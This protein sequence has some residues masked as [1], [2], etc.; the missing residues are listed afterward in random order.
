[1]KVLYIVG[2]STGGLPHYTA[3]LAN[4]VAEHA[5]VT[6]MKPK[7]TT[8]DELF[9][10][11]V[12]LLTAFDHLGVSMPELYSFD[13]NPLDFV[14][15]FLSYDAIREIEDVDAD[16]VHDTTDL[17]PQVK[18]FAKRHGIDA[19]FPL[20]V[21][22]HEVSK[23]RLS[24]S[25]PPV[26]VEE[27]LD[28]AI[29]DLDLDRVVVHTEKQRR[30]MTN[31]GVPADR[32]SIIPHGAYS[33]F[34]SD[35]DVDV[36]PE[37]NCLLFFGHIVT[38]K[39]LDTLVE[40]IP[41]VKR[42]IP[43][44]KLIIA[45]EGKIPRRSRAIME[46]HEGNFEVHNYFVPNEEVKDIFGRAEVVA[47]PYRNQGGTKGHSGA[48]A[49]AFSFGKPVVASTAGEFTSLVG[50]TGSGLVV[51][52]EDPE[53]LASAIIRLLTDEDAKREMSACSSRMADRLSWDNVAEQYVDVY[54]R[55][56]DGAGR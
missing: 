56:L 46:A 26:L 2:Q 31:R 19:R 25:R 37:R 33:V 6:V 10:D 48:L 16:V 12:E 43:D 17:F 42:E 21:T 8:A 4:A 45:G 40:A 7:E 22:R 9:D 35:T 1:M 27:L 36:D 50:D 55:V 39:G 44:V 51:P 53:R 34:G 14:R 54:E 47:L 20:V 49:T 13:V 15:G 41:L 3:E 32:I 28:Y 18:L 38:P 23:R 11:E 52:P 24:F 30:A 29:P 5:D